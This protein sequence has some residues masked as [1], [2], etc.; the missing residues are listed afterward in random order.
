M[1]RF[2][3]WLLLVV[4]TWYLAA[5]FRTPSLTVLLL[6]ELALLA[7]MFCLS[8]YFRGTLDAAFPVEAAFGEK[9][10]DCPCSIVLTARGRLPAGRPRV[11]LALSYRKT[12]RGK[13][14]QRFYGGAEPRRETESRFYVRPPYCGA[15]DIELRQI[16][17]WDYLFLFPARRRKREHMTLMVLPPPRALNIAAPDT[18]GASGMNPQD[19]V[20]APTDGVSAETRDLREYRPGD[21]ARGIHW[22]LSARTGTLWSREYE[23]EK[24]A[25]FTLSL[26]LS[27]SARNWDAFYEVLS[28]IVLGLL[29]HRN[30]V[31]IYWRDGGRDR[32]WETTDE[33]S[34][35]AFFARLYE[36]EPPTGEAE[37]VLTDFTLDAGLNWRRGDALIWRFDASDAVREIEER[38]FVI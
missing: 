20:F 19:A 37:A 10:R 11:T 24:E 38:A 14:V 1:T 25:R 7:A 17:T 5:M 22:K 18:A 30:A 23:E 31:R 26:S 28:A 12:R 33:R 13:T 35:K 16:L 36:S 34:R 32:Q 21:S 8:L 4:L 27:E 2:W 29:R 6:S 3:A 9:E 15:L